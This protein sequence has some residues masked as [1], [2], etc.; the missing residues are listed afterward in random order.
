[1]LEHLARLRLLQSII[2][3]A[4]A[5]LR[6]QNADSDADIA[7]DLTEQVN[8]PLNYEIEYIDLSWRRALADV[9]SRRR[10]RQEA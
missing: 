9:G 4:V 10:M 2:S 8:E 1:V 7:Y 6:H 5:V 3:D